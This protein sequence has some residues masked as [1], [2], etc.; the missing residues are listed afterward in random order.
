MSQNLDKT[1]VPMFKVE[2]VRDREVVA[3][4]RIDKAE[5]AAEVLHALLDKCPV[6]KFIVLYMD[7]AGELV[8]GEEVCM[9]GLERVEV[10]LRNVFRGAILAC[11]SR[12]II[13]HNHPQGAVTASEEDL[14]LT[15]VAMEYGMR[16][17]I[18]VWDHIVVSPKGDFYS[19]FEHRDRILELAL[20]KIAG[21]KPPGFGK[22]PYMDP[23]MDPLGKPPSAPKP[24]P[25]M[26]NPFGDFFGR[27]PRV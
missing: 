23:Y 26:H 12:I 3:P 25:L 5:Q 2:L 4:K 20:K 7:A 19:I 9:G 6:E 18:E 10:E 27:K 14:I 1:V 17:G 8:G 24:K 21:A 22:D 15:A 16:L 11:V 13:A